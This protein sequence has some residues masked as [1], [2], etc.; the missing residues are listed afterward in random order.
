[1]DSGHQIHGRI[2]RE[3]LLGFYRS[4]GT[5]QRAY[6]VLAQRHSTRDGF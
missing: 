6:L 3:P 4:W 2:L 5:L 1:M